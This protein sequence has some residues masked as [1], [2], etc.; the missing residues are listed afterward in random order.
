MTTERE[1]QKEKKESENKSKEKEVILKESA[2]SLCPI[3]K[4]QYP[5]GAKC[6]QC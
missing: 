1:E 6:P 2:Y 5:R 3:H 4:V